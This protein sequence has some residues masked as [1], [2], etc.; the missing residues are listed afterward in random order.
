MLNT[1]SDGRRRVGRSWAATA[2]RLRSRPRGYLVA[3]QL[4]L[5]SGD[6]LVWVRPVKRSFPDTSGRKPLKNPDPAGVGIGFKSPSSHWSG[7]RRAG[8]GKMA[9]G[10]AR[11]VKRFTSGRVFKGLF[12]FFRAIPRRPETQ[13]K[14]LC[15]KRLRA[16]V[17]FLVVGGR[18]SSNL[19]PPFPV[20]Q[21]HSL[22]ALT[23]GARGERFPG[24]FPF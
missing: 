18:R 9:G 17:G 8:H 5:T 3:L 6:A 14:S 13:R 11:E 22:L 1:A 20:H 15:R 21:S 24:G 23:I 7:H 4:D 12:G 10:L 2:A 16:L 19:P